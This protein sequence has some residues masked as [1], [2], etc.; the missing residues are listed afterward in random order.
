MLVSG[1]TIAK[2]IAKLDILRHTITKPHQ[3]LD[4]LRLYT[5]G[6]R[7]RCAFPQA[8]FDCYV[9]LDRQ[10]I[11]WNGTRNLIK[12]GEHRSLVG[13]FDSCLIFGYYEGKNWGQWCGQAHLETIMCR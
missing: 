8:E 2:M 7:E 12:L 11:V 1:I 6:M 5:A 3:L 13:R 4:D 10:F 9:P